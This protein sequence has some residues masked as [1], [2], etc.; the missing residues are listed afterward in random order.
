M[1]GALCTGSQILLTTWLAKR[2]ESCR[3]GAH[4]RESLAQDLEVPFEEASKTRNPAPAPTGS[5]GGFWE[6][7]H[8]LL[9][10]WPGTASVWASLAFSSMT[11]AHPGGHRW[12]L[13]QGL[14][15]GWVERNYS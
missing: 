11:L 10:F 3:R 15:G 7:S 12:G 1:V 2:T 5:P 9:P 4:H 14:V 6:L 13:K 8:F